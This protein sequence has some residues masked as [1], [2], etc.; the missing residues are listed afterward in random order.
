[1]ESDLAE[2]GHDASN[3]QVWFSLVPSRSANLN[4]RKHAGHELS[5][6]HAFDKNVHEVAL[7]IGLQVAGPKVG[8][9]YFVVTAGRVALERLWKTRLP[10]ARVVI[11]TSESQYYRN[12]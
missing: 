12:L 6:P 4:G 1:M 10:T 8:Y 5:M 11:D 2:R 9:Q 3:K 7:E